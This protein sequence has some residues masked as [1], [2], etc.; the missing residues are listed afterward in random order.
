VP[1]GDLCSP[2]LDGPSEAADLD[3][4]RLI[5]EVADDLSNPL[6][7]EF[8]VACAQQADR[9]FVGIDGE[10]LGAIESRRRTRQSGSSRRQRCPQVSFCTRGAPR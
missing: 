2:L 8:G 6:V 5:S 7:S 1:C 4:H 3:G 10:S 9:S